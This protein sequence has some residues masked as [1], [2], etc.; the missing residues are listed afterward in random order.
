MK[1]QWFKK[2]V[3][4]SALLFSATGYAGVVTDVESV[5]ALVGW[6][7]EVSW[8]HDLS[9]TDFVLGSAQSATISIQLR[10][11][12]S[13]WLDF[14]EVAT[15]VIDAVD[16]Q[17]GQFLY[18]P[19]NDWTG[20]LGLNS[21]I[22]LNA[23]GLLNVTVWSD[24]GDFFVGNST[25]QVVTTSVPEPGSLALLGLGLLGLGLLRRRSAA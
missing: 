5:N 14:I 16:F 25:L 7:G 8:T 15:I 2:L 9:D 18:I 23:T 19:T 6:G 22:T 11:D 3:A 4:A 1:L 17:D 20:L 24:I 13:S 21:L 12:S 10:D